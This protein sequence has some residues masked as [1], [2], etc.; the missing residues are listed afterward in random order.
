MMREA[1][2]G[3]C[4]AAQCVL[5]MSKGPFCLVMASYGQGKV[6]MFIKKKKSKH[7]P[8][9]KQLDGSLLSV[10]Y[11]YF[12]FV[13]PLCGYLCSRQSVDLEDAIFSLKTKQLLC[14]Q[15]HREAATTLSRT[16]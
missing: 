1:M 2:I 12:F 10:A 9:P 13:Q 14:S 3:F 15:G 5:Y 16:L 8:N 7:N 6:L 4:A 11:H